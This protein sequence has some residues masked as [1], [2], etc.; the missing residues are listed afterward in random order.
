M[1]TRP[2]ATGREVTGAL[3][4]MAEPDAFLFVS[5]ADRRSCVFRRHGEE[6]RVTRVVP[7][8]AVRVMLD[9]G[10]LELQARGEQTARFCIS[11]VGRGR[12]RAA[13]EKERRSRRA[14]QSA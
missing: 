1:P 11:E 10:L 7:S 14:A 6:L 12:L 3:R 13:L 4:R 9:E 8:P 2:D 5:D